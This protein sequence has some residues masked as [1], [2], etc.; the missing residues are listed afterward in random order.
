M[1]SNLTVKW[2]E[3]FCT[4]GFFFNFFVY[5]FCSFSFS[6]VICTSAQATTK[7]H[8]YVI[9]LQHYKN[10]YIFFIDRVKKQNNNNFKQTERGNKHIYTHLIVCNKNT[11]RP[12]RCGTGA[13]L[14]HGTA[15]W[16]PQV[17]WEGRVREQEAGVGAGPIKIGIVQLFLRLKNE[18]NG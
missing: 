7:I 12:V 1:T 14:V 15:D 16:F 10:M 5:L 2:E 6:H 4:F 9:H 8:I 17:A 3:L 18:W 13:A 11:Y